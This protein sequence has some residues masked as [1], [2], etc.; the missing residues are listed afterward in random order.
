M[1]IALPLLALRRAAGC[2]AALQDPG[3][4]G[5]ATIGP[6]SSVRGGGSLHIV[7]L[8]GVR[9]LADHG[10]SGWNDG[11]AT[12][13]TIGGGVETRGSESALSVQEGR[14]LPEV[15]PDVVYSSLPDGAVLLSTREEVYFGL[16]RTGARIWELL[17]EAATVDELCS[18][19]RGDFPDAPNGQLRRDVLDL[20]GELEE[21]GLVASRGQ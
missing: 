16:N 1:C 18:E 4:Y 3:P 6:A 21:L 17:Q 19:L 7:V 8:Q 12:I 2:V 15:D 11:C 13:T 14:S 20:L 5:S 9:R 10:P